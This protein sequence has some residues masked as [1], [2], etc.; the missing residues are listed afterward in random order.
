MR[1][2]KRKLTSIN[3]WL[4]TV[5][6]TAI[7]QAFV[8]RVCR[9]RSP[10]GFGLYG[11]SVRRL[12]PAI[13]LRPKALCGMSISI[14]PCDPAELVIYEEIFVDR[15]YDLSGLPFVP[16]TVVDCGAYQG[17]FTLLART[18]YPSARFIAIEPHPDNYAIMRHNF[19]RNGTEVDCLALAV[20]NR[21]GA[22]SLVG[23][24]CGARLC[25]DQYA[26]CANTVQVADLADVLSPLSSRRLLLKL[27]VEGEEEK[28]LPEIVP[29]LPATCAVFFEWHHGLTR[30]DEV[31]NLFERYG[32]SVQCSRTRL[33]DAVDRAFVDATAVRHFNSD[34]ASITHQALI[35]SA[36]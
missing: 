34:S 17:H 11:R 30:F 8:L 16:D 28:I 36:R 14:R 6:V 22:M 3:K 7:P 9:T 19:D 25:S 26:A 12:F 2:F 29:R 13:S 20:S 15:V 33:L 21:T 4:A 35:A 5:P 31:R 27:D 32:F 24:G 10:N 18:L 23:D 1:Q